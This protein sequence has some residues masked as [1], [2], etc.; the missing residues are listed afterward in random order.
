MKLWYISFVLCKYHFWENSV[1]RDLGDLRFWKTWIFG[2]TCLI[3]AKV[4]PAHMH[5]EK[6]QCCRAKNHAFSKIKI[7]DFWR[8]RYKECK[9][10]SNFGG[11]A[12]SICKADALQRSS[13]DSIWLVETKWFRL[14]RRSYSAAAK[15]AIENANE[16]FL[17][18]RYKNDL[19]SRSNGWISIRFG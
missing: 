13:D 15:N 17:D 10:L 6:D 19:R 9:V 8:S 1:V 3:H 14:G 11:P 16:L 18:S 4:S 7:S 12:A 5:V 2:W